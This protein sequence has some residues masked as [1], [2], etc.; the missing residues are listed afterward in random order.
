MMQTRGAPRTERHRPRRPLRAGLPDLGLPALEAAA[1]GA[2][3]P[4]GANARTRASS[5]RFQEK[6]SGGPRSRHMERGRHGT[7]LCFR[8]TIQDLVVVDDSTYLID[9]IDL[10]C[11]PLQA[12]IQAW[13]QF[14]ARPATK[15]DVGS[16]LHQGYQFSNQA[17]GLNLLPGWLSLRTLFLTG[18]SW[19]T[20]VRSSHPSPLPRLDK[21]ASHT[22]THVSSD[23]SLQVHS[24]WA[25]SGGIPVRNRREFPEAQYF[26]SNPNEGTEGQHE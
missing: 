9:V 6:R 2:R 26:W 23:S 5:I 15:A 12:S 22:E 10:I 8:W 1:L 24:F 7:R 21:K 16:A 4:A 3:S 20:T 19:K 13:F 14:V 17:F 18:G 11:F 25:T